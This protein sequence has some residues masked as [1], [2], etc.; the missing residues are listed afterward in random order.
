MEKSRISSQ[1]IGQIN[2]SVFQV[3][4]KI[5]AIYIKLHDGEIVK[6]KEMAN[7]DVVLD[8]DKKGTVIGIEM[9]EPVNLRISKKIQKKA[10]ELAGININR[11]QGAFAFA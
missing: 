4:N 11:L 2:F 6:S 3:D 1:R 7:G 5:N 9:L 10:P 8:L